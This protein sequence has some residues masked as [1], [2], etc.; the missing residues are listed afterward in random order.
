MQHI[1]ISLVITYLLFSQMVFAQKST[2]TKIVKE[3]IYTLAEVYPNTFARESAR[4]NLMAGIG[5][6]FFNSRTSFRGE[7]FLTS[8]DSIY[9][10]YENRRS[11]DHREEKQ[12]KRDLYG[13]G[14]KRF[15]DGF[16][17]LYFSVGAK[18]QTEINIINYD[19][20]S[21]VDDADNL[22]EASIGGQINRG[23]FTVGCDVLT[24]EAEVNNSGYIHFGDVFAGITF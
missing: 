9:F 6:S 22:V 21:F 8:Q 13:G 16:D 3:K 20:S 7:Y 10:K 5:Y 17:Y 14:Y 24:F 15:L 1:K 19:G 4:F 12:R 11:R 18:H 2:K 23:Y